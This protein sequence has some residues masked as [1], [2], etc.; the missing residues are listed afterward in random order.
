MLNLK[1]KGILRNHTKRLDKLMSYFF[2]LG[3]NKKGFSVAQIPRLEMKLLF[4]L[5]CGFRA[6]VL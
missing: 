2:L 5:S 1:R 4:L 3:Q 6:T